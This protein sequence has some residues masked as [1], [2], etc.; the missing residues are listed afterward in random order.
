M[1]DKAIQD[2]LEQLA[3]LIGVDGIVRALG[4]LCLMLATDPTEME[5][6][7]CRGLADRLQN[8]QRLKPRIVSVYIDKA[9]VQ[10]GHPEPITIDDRQGSI[11]HS[12]TL[13]INGPS[14]L[15]YDPNHKDGSCLWLETEE[16]NLSC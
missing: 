13:T 6:A 15:V 14:R 7:H 2:Q 3:Q 8:I 5:Q 4:R 16:E 12:G 11:R 1:D 10:A 9:R